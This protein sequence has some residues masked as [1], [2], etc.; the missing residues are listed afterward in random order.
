MYRCITA[1]LLLVFLVGASS[2]SVWADDCPLTDLTDDCRVDLID[3]SI[4]EFWYKKSLSELLLIQE[5][6]QLSGD[7]IINLVDLS[8]MGFYWTG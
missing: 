7:G 6:V 3:F 2:T 5:K 1:L 8:I 4:A